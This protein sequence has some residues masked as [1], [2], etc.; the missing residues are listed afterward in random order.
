MALLLNTQ[1]FE[2]LRRRAVIRRVSLSI[3]EGDRLGL[4][5]PNGSGKSTLLEILAGRREPDTGE[6]VLRKGTRL[7][8]RPAGF[9]VR[10][11]ETVRGVIRRALALRGI[12]GIGMAGAR[13]GNPGPRRIRGF[14]RGGRDAVRRLAQAPRHR[15]SAG[16]G[17]RHPAAR[18]A[19][20]SPGPGRHRV[21]GKTAAGRAVRLRDGQPRPLLP[22]KR[23]HRDGRA[24]PRL[25]RRHVL[26]P[27]QLQRVSRKEGR[28]P[29]R[30][31]Q[32]AGSAGESR[33]DRNGMAAARSQGARHQ[34]Q[35]AHRQGPRDD[36]RTGRSQVP[37]PHRTPRISILPPRTGRPSA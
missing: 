17:A 6:V 13:G 5:G 7:G 2:I 25:S 26:R 24:E 14:R 37:K 32:A 11:G 36:R 16:A 27:R 1:D 3:Q 8:L 35:G 28:V 31:G 4:I 18:R 20:Q 15:R 30:A 10:P 21:A 34:S 23:G 22:R 33:A 12:A 9:A 29:A 19:H